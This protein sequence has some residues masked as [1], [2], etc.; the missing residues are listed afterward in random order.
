MI[1]NIT[2]ATVAEKPQTKY[3]RY[4]PKL[5]EPLTRREIEVIAHVL[6]GVT[7]AAIGKALFIHEK[8]V[9]FHLGRI[10]K[11]LGIANRGQ[12]ILRECERE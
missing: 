3:E 8:T 2:S 12:L 4:K 10:Y 1:D 11:K 7:N 9:K 6:H 5:G